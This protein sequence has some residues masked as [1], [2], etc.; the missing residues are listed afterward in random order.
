MPSGWSVR[1]ACCN[2]TDM[3]IS[4]KALNSYYATGAYVTFCRIMSRGRYITSLV[5][6]WVAKCIELYSNCY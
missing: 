6:I 5:T 1:E 3:M 4:I 2:V